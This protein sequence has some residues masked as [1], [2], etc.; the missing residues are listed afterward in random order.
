MNRQQGR[1]H[2]DF[3][4]M[5]SGLHDILRLATVIPVIVI[6]DVRHAAPLAE[7]LVA[8]GLPVLEVTLRTPAALE[9]VTAMRRAVPDAIVGV[10]TI[11]Q[12]SQVKSA[13]DAGA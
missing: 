12:G 1:F 4:F 6:D 8:G 7:A 3:A 11:T 13:V 9:A 5:S 2:N 10:G